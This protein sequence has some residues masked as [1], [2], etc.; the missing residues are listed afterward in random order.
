MNLLWNNEH[1]CKEC[2]KEPPEIKLHIDHIIPVS[3]GG[4]S[5]SKNLQFL[6]NECNLKKKNKLKNVSCFLKLGI[7]KGHLFGENVNGQK[8]KCDLC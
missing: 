4:K 8:T 3:L 2:G 1:V 7:K 5:D 6:C